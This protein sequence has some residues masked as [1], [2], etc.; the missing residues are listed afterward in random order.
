MGDALAGGVNMENQEAFVH[1]LNSGNTREHKVRAFLAKPPKRA[2]KLIMAAAGE[3]E[4]KAL[5]L[6][7]WQREEVVPA[8]S[9]DIIE[10]LEEHAQEVGGA[11]ECQLIYFDKDGAQVQALMLK[12]Q[13]SQ[14][15]T[16]TDL[17]MKS[18]Q[19]DARSLVVQAQVQSLAVQKLY[20]SSMSQVLVVSQQIAGRAND[21]AEGYL[22]RIVDL[23]H[24][25]ERLKEALCAL[26]EM[27]AA[28][29]PA[30]A[31]SPAQEEALGLLKQLVPVLMAKLLAPSAAAA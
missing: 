7:E 11:V 21:Q 22:R 31:T 20:L 6:G 13:A 4:T 8:L 24:E 28:E 12:R 15:E 16:A 14:I 27:A 30:K 1:G 18:V 29:G 3:E 23:E 9:T 17:A 10:R 25:N 2:A 5:V 26:E 19:G